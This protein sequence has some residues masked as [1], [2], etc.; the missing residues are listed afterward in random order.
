MRGL[1]EEEEARAAWGEE[2]SNIGCRRRVGVNVLQVPVATM[3]VYELSGVG[4]EP[5]VTVPDGFPHV[6]VSVSWTS[7]EKLQGSLQNLLGVGIASNTHIAPFVHCASS[8][9][10]R[11]EWMMN[12]FMYCAVSGKRKRAMPS[13]PPFDVPKAILNKGVSVG[14]RMVK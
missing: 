6:H 3:L 12:W 13:P 7:V 8:N 1:V 4:S 9:M 11:L 5:Q 2:S 14:D 10:S